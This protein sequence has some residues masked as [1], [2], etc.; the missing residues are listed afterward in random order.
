MIRLYAGIAAIAVLG[1]LGGGWYVTSLKL[2]TANQALAQARAY[3]TAF[4]AQLNREREEVQRVNLL[5]SD[6][7][8]KEAEIRYVDRV[9]QKEVI[10]YRDRVINRCQLSEHWLRIHNEAATGAGTDSGPS[11]VQD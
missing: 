7:E 1:A 8:T 4:E 6:L 5:L 3:A 11:E 9:V 10:K 2:Y